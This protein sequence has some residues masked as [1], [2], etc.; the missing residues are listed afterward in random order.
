MFERFVNGNAGTQLVGGIAAGAGSIV[1]GDAGVFPPAG[2]FPVQIDNELMLVTAIAGN[3]LTV[4][5]GAEGTTAASHADNARVEWGMSQGVLDR[6]FAELQTSGTFG[7]RPLAGAS[8]EGQAWRATNGPYLSIY[9]NGVWQVLYPLMPVTPPVVSGLAWVNQG[10]ATGDDSKGILSIVAPASAGGNNLRILKKALPGVTYTVDLAIA[11]CTSPANFWHAGIAL[12]ESGT[13]KLCTWGL[14]YDLAKGG[15]N[16]AAIHWTN[17][18]TFSAY[19]FS[20]PCRELPASIR[21]LRVVQD[22]T[23]RAFWGSP[24]GLQ[25]QLFGVETKLTFLTENEVGPFANV[26]NGTITAAA[27]FPHLAVS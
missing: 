9:K 18:T 27:S 17:E 19:V 12:R 7:T 26:F 24:D 23:N 15:L 11:P 25:W 16:L 4:T 21:Y 2:R 10:T 14:G 22:S 6:S 20:F 1:V 5:R 13:G 3:T 8:F